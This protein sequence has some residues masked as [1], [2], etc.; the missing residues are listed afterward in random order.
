[1]F[2]SRYNTEKR[3]FMRME[4]DCPLSYSDLEGLRTREGKCINLSAK[5]IAFE[6]PESF[7]LGAELKVCLV[8]KLD[9]TPPF[10][11][12]IKIVRA[13]RNSAKHNYTLAAQI[14]EVI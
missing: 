6:A 5:G 11:A 10:S 13:E 9:M 4:M 1:M 8:P 2:S 12:K 14:E 3:K 7:P